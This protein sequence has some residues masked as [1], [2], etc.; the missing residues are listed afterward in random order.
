MQS[1]VLIVFA[2]NFF[3]MGFLYIIVVRRQIMPRLAKLLLF[4]C[5]LVSPVFIAIKGV[6]SIIFVPDI[7]G[8]YLV[9]AAA[10]RWRLA[11][12]QLHRLRF[13]LLTFLLIWPVLMTCIVMVSGNDDGTQFDTRGLQGLAIW[14][15]RNTVLFSIFSLAL[16]LQLSLENFKSFLFGFLIMSI[17]M[18][19]L[20]GINYLRIYNLAIFEQILDSFQPWDSA[21]KSTTTTFG[22][23]YLGM[24]RGSMGQWFAN[25]SLLAVA[26][27]T[28]L[29]GVKKIM[30]LAV[31]VAS[32]VLV[33][34]SFSRAGLVATGVGLFIY[35]LL[36]GV[37]G[38]RL[39]ILAA[40]CSVAVFPLLE[41]GMLQD[42]I[43]SI[44]GYA[45]EKERNRVD[46]WNDAI[47]YFSED[48]LDF[49]IGVGATNRWKVF[50]IIGA[51]GAHNEYI[52]TIFRSGIGGVVFLLAFLFTSVKKST[53][54]Y[55]RNTGARTKAIF[56]IGPAL[57]LSNMVIGITQDHLY[58]SFSSYSTGPMM[59][60]LYGVLLSLNAQRRSIKKPIEPRSNLSLRPVMELRPSLTAT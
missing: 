33:L 32:I 40:V 31:A 18:I 20:A 8:P 48:I 46:G 55:F 58:R 49:S 21:Y 47:T 39:I 24:F 26:A 59:Y 57:I 30:A 52:D 3:C 36:L 53:S 35:A 13:L 28:I 11:N 2:I 44:S 4:M 5:F 25:S 23:G 50:K 12:L 15:Y 16:S 27:F 22:W 17:A 43:S 56:A 6:E 14:L 51:F 29:P 34:I 10:M 42:R 41:V 45:T 9:I 19:G 38:W 54:L 7:I 60:L 37:R 1:K